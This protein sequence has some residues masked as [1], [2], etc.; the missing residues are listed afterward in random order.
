MMSPG[1]FT[2]RSGAA[3]YFLVTAGSLLAQSH[4]WKIIPGERVGP[5]TP[6]SGLA[7]L[8]R[9]FGA[10]NVR[11]EPIHVGEGFYEPGVVIYKEK[12]S[13]TLGVVW[14]KGELPQRPHVVYICYGQKR[15]GACEWK[16][17]EGISL[18]TALS[19]LE[20]L[21]RRPFSLAGFGWDYGGVVL[22]WNGGL[23]E[24]SLQ[25]GGR[26]VLLLEP[27]EAAATNEANMRDY[28]QVIGDHTFSSS[29]PAMLK[30]DPRVYAIIVEFTAAPH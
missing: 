18:R 22:G 8:Q 5:L 27:A 7:D 9:Q 23:L 12:P 6:A 21:N 17:P 14:Q 24:A 2:L 20:K 29:H 11:E 1:E 16:T 25:K 15:D 28:G 30:L 19:Q 4:D 3:L 26:V 13:R 10:A